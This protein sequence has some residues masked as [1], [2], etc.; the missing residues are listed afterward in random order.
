MSHSLRWLTMAAFA[1]VATFAR[2][3]FH[4]FQI[5]QMYSNAD[6]S[7]Q[8][9]VLHESQ[10]MNGE[11]FLVP[12]DADISALDRAGEALLPVS[13]VLARLQA[14]VPVTIVLLDACRSN[15][16]PAGATPFDERVLSA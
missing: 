13:S 6:G 1:L 15:P 3:E 12:V 8:F 4:T 14:T 9:V 10:G 11:N 7:V 5:E 16:F 2:A